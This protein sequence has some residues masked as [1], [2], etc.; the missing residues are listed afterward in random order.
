MHGRVGSWPKGRGFD[1]CSPNTFLKNLP[2][3]KSVYSEKGWRIKH[4]LNNASFRISR[5]N[6]LRGLEIRV[7]LHVLTF[8]GVV[9][10]ERS[11]QNISKQHY[12]NDRFC[13]YNPLTGLWTW[14]KFCHCY[15]TEYK[16]IQSILCLDLFIW[17]CPMR[18]IL[19]E[20]SKG[21]VKTLVLQYCCTKK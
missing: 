15:C 11:L 2:F 5:N 7:L 19:C 1:S 13:I 10:F 21:L 18:K 4:N 6:L 17:L 3:W 12:C 20:F 16:K 14:V 8:W 9:E